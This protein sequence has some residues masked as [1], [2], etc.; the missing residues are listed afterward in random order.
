MEGSF[1]FFVVHTTKVLEVC[2]FICGN[3]RNII[4]MWTPKFSITQSELSFILEDLLKGFGQWWDASMITSCI[5][6]Q[7]EFKW[8]ESWSL[9]QSL[10]WKAVKAWTE[11]VTDRRGDVQLGWWVTNSR[12]QDDNFVSLNIHGIIKNKLCNPQKPLAIVKYPQFN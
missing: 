3:S 5:N 7:N 6:V 4:F 10:K 8:E 1:F 11:Q 2:S 9:F 12:T